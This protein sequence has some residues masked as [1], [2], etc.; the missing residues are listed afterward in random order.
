MRSGRAEDGKQRRMIAA[1]WRATFSLA[2]LALLLF[3]SGSE[4]I[5]IQPDE[6]LLT[7]S[8]AAVLLVALALFFSAV[9]WK[10]VLGPHGPRVGVLWR[11]YVIGWFFS[12]FLP[13]SIGGDAVRTV[14]LARSR[15]STGAAISSVLIE[16]LLGVAALAGLLALGLLTVSSG[17]AGLTESLRLDLTPGR[18]AFAMGAVIIAGG[19]GATIAAR[20]GRVQEL[21]R[22]AMS[23]I[24]AFRLRPIGL[25]AAIAAS[26]AVQGLYIL[27]WVAL[28]WSIRLPVP[29]SSFL[30][31][32]PL[33]S[34]AAMVPITLAGLGLREGAWVVL[35]APTGIAA[36]QAVSF[37][38]LYYGV[39]LVVGIAGAILFLTSGLRTSLQ[40]EMN[41][42]GSHVPA[43]DTVPAV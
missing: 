24:H 32:V 8:L 15:T 39:G 21:L 14:A 23:V 18:L 3:R 37:S 4:G 35:L 13:T 7:G 2:I 11:L 28:A 1:A 42:D 34:V 19:L 40:A 26:F 31:W 25:V 20:S 29:A 12:L 9:R 22:D 27:T 30:I 10:L 43:P 41:D 5:S 6:R 36:A 16:R 33:I 17:R 38:L